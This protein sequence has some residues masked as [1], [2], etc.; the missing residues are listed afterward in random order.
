M[1]I[2]E[3]VYNI[4]TGEDFVPAYYQKGYMASLLGVPIYIGT[5][6]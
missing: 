3:G 5:Y 2:K 4:A 6:C 1:Q